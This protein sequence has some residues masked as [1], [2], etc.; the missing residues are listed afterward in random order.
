[1]PALTFQ[2]AQLFLLQLRGTYYPWLHRLFKSAQQLRVNAIGL[3]QDTTGT[4]K[5]SYP[6]GWHQA[7]FDL[8]SNQG[9]NQCSFVATAGLTNHLHWPF[10]L[11]KPLDQSSLPNC[12]IAASKYALAIS[13]PR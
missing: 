3:S 5:L 6:V 11:F 13:T 10:D 2:F 12:A 8:C 7:H 1:M 4:R 9:P